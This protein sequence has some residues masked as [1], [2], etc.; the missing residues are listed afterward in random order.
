MTPDQH[1][2]DDDG[3]AIGEL[4]TATTGAVRAP[5]SLRARVAQERMRAGA[6]RPDRRRRGRVAALAS[7]GVALAAAVALA[8][9]GVSG[10][11]T[12]P[13]VDDAVAFAL[14]RPTAPPP[15]HDPGN[16]DVV[17]AQEG[18]V[19]FPNYANDG[20]EALRTVGAR[21]DRVHGR[22]A[23]TVVYDG[24]GGNVGYTIV[25]GDPLPIPDGS[26]T[27]RSG[28]V[29]L[30]ALQRNGA[31]VVTWRRGGHTCVLASR[32]APAEQLVR[33]ATWT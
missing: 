28:G 26:R 3:A 25:G 17:Q 18:G 1:D 13:S 4:I 14:A 20:W 27:I 19:R 8:I 33:M 22:H 21:S 31:T 6:M 23:T 2:I 5:G 32:S 30:W 11:G 15:A 16:H 29:T 7:T 10:S 9:V 12:Q 24:P